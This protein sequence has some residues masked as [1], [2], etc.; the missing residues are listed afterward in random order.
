M[1]GELLTPGEVADTFRVEV[2]TVYKWVREGHLPKV[3]LPG[4]G[5]RYRL[6]K[7]DVEDFINADAP[8]PSWVSSLREKV[9]ERAADSFDDDLRVS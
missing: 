1:A 3:E 8:D 4:G 7:K 9:R 6:R 2:A 5:R